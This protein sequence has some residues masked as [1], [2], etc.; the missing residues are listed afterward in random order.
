MKLPKGFRL[1]RIGGMDLIKCGAIN[2]LP[3]FL[4]VFTTRKGGK[5]RG[6]YSAL[7]TGVHTGDEVKT[8]KNNIKLIERA[9][10]IKYA[11]AANQVHG[12][13]VAVIQPQGNKKRLM[14]KDVVD[15][16]KLLKTGVD[17]II[18]SGPGIAAGVRLADCVGTVIA[19]PANMVIASVHSGWKGIAADIPGKA[20]KKM[21]KYFKSNPAGLIA[22]VSPAIGP[23]CYEVGEE[24]YNQLHKQPVFSNIF[25][26]RKGRIYMDLWAGV[27]NLL[28]RAGLKE[29]NIHVCNI[30]T[31]DNPEYF[32]SHRRDKGRTGRQMAIGAVIQVVKPKA[33][34]QKLSKTKS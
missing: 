15:L 19:D 9:L 7:N 25:K 18:T 24:L 32:Y 34:R 8:V 16:K 21:K 2:D 31:F 20:V 28:L 3:G 14:G 4:Q 10:G 13:H 1:E 23:C 29:K 6:F 27:R 5:S 30:C 22:A 26:R 12:D 17:G 33:K 11:S